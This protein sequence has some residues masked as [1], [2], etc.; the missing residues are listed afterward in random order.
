MGLAAARVVI[1]GGTSGIGLATAKAAAAKEADVVVVSSR[2][3]SVDSALQQLPASAEGRVVDISS[4]AA[5][6]EFFATVG[7][8]DHLVYTAGEGLEMTPLASYDIDKARRFF[9]L[10][11]FLA[12]EAVRLAVPHLRADGSIALTSG[13]AALRPSA[14]WT[15]GAAVSGAMVSAGKALAVELAPLRVNVIAPGVVRSPLWSAMSDEDRSAMYEYVGS[16]LPLGRVAE[17]DDVAAE[18]VHVMEQE[19]ATGTVTV[20]DGGSVLV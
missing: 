15:L 11:F 20:I 7:E 12:L 5:L 4:V 13:T 17:V 3:A 10:R 6:E 14:G 2:K 19:Y 16:Q 8:F 18:Y 9:D 1:L